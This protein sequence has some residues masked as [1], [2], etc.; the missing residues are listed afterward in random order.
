MYA[1]VIEDPL[2]IGVAVR[3][4]S[5]SVQGEAVDLGNIVLDDTLPEIIAIDPMSG[6]KNTT[7]ENT[8]RKTMIATRSLLV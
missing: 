7:P 8:I 1:F 2:G 3:M 4:L 5:I 6:A